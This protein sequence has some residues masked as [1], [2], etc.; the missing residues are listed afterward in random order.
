MFDSTL[1]TSGGNNSRRIYTSNWASILPNDKSFNVS[2][3]FMSAT[4]AVLG[5]IPVLFIPILKCNLGQNTTFANLTSL[6]SA[7]TTTNALGFLKV[8]L[9]PSNNIASTDDNAY[10]VA[11]I[12]TNPSIYL[13]SRPTNSTLEVEIH[14]GLTNT[15]YVNI[16][17]YVL[18]LHF[19]ECDEY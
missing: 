1:H 15:N 10:L 3:S 17:D 8:A 14:N 2:F 16:P 7:F 12:T 9:V 18:T 5:V 6:S 4:D 13:K 11:D 19:E